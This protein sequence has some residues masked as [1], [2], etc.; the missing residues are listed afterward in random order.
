M[1]KIKFANSPQN[2]CILQSKSILKIMKTSEEIYKCIFGREKK[3]QQK[4]KS[5]TRNFSSAEFG[6]WDTLELIFVFA[7][8]RNIF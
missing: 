7:K 1:Y 8:E 5:I 3:F 2:H 6:Q 4:N